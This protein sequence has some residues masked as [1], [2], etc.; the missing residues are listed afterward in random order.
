MEVFIV[1]LLVFGSFVVGCF[2]GFMFQAL[3]NV[4]AM[5]MGKAF[6]KKK[7]GRWYP[8]NPF[9]NSEPPNTART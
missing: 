3:V 2:V 1:G 7:D 9:R 8:Y 4:S 6:F 5:R